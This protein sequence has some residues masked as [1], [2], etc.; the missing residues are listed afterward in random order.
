MTDAPRTAPLP[1]SAFDLGGITW[2]LSCGK[3]P[4]PRRASDALARFLERERR[5]WDLTWQEGFLELPGRIRA[6]AARLVGGEPDDITLVPSTSDALIVVARGL[7]LD[8]GDEIL[9]PLGEFPSNA[10]PWRALGRRGVS[11][12]E[13]P[14]WDGQ[15]AGEHAWDS[16]PPPPG[17]DPESRL[18]EAIGPRTR[19]V[20]A[21]WVRFQDGLRLDTARLGETCRQRGV[22][23][24]VD[25]IQGAG[26]LPIDV[27]GSAAFATNGHKGL[28]GPQGLGFLWTHPAFRRELVPPGGW[29]AVE[30]AID[31]SRA[32]T[33]FERGWAEDGTRL[34]GGVP[35]LLGCV[36]LGE[37]LALIEQA[38]VAAISAWT[39][40]LAR[41]LL[42]GLSG[43]GTWGAEARR[44][45]ALFDEGRGSA[46]V[47]LHHGGRG[48]AWLQG[49]LE[50]GFERRVYASVREGYLR[51]GFHGYND[52]DD[53][54]R[55]LAWLTSA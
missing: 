22:T 46:I 12:R 35:N 28:L 14:L 47:S 38:G 2:V 39:E 31:F 25:G 18:A 34:E 19:L 44:A 13:V 37:S 20:S 29:L 32:S 4:L 53:V 51:I 6:S 3:G 10:W 48:Q 45:R 7:T 42:E 52:D 40:R 9:L 54:D 49:V 24:V 21:S 11:V 17:C 1:K 41:R 23:L 30:Q 16:T 50:S 43:S 55:I 8:D 5:P 26:T 27:S 15:L 33:D 36:A